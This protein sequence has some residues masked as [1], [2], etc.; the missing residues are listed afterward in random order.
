MFIKANGPLDEVT[1]GGLRRPPEVILVVFQRG[2][3]RKAEFLKAI[4]HAGLV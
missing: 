4:H 3:L 1:I 2:N